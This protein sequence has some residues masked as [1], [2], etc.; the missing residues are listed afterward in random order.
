MGRFRSEI[1]L[2]GS[3]RRSYLP[4]NSKRRIRTDPFRAW[5]E[6]SRNRKIQIKRLYPGG[7]GER[8]RGRIPDLY[9][10]NIEFRRISS[11]FR[12]CREF[13]SVIL[14]LEE[15]P[16]REECVEDFPP[17]LI[18]SK[19]ATLERKIRS[20][21]WSGRLATVQTGPKRDRIGRKARP[22]KKKEI[23][24]G[25]HRNRKRESYYAICEKNL[26]GRKNGEI[27]GRYAAN[28]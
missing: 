28:V 10:Y 8:R 13:L 7:G 12:E 4:Y 24:Q 22:K 26:V 16:D 19:V 14:P 15:T 17:S 3:A 5:G 1:T 27:C 23:Q 2:S 20:F 11:S 9:R 25:S 21:R 18:P 6:F